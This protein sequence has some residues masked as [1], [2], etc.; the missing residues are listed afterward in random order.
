MQGRW[1]NPDD[2][3][4]TLADF[5]NR[6]IGER[7]GLRPRTV[8]LYRSLFGNHIVPDLG[9]LTLGGAGGCSGPPLACYSPERWGLS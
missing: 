8:D 4:V 9:S 7:P 1:I 6:W 2:Q 5:G 3:K